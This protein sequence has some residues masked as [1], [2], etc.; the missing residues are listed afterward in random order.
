MLE[1][2]SSSCSVSSAPSISL[3]SASASLRRHHAQALLGAYYALQPCGA[4]AARDATV[5]TH[6]RWAAPCS[7]RQH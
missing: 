1:A 7:V 4:T 3:A 5:R 6:R 2:M